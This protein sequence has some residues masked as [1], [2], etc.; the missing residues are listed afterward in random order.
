[1]GSQ[2]KVSGYKY[3]NLCKGCGKVFKSRNTAYHTFDGLST[4]PHCGSKDILTQGSNGKIV[5]WAYPA[6]N[7][8][9]SDFRNALKFDIEFRE[10]PI[11]GVL[12]YQGK[13]LFFK[14]S[15][16]EKEYEVWE[17]KLEDMEYLLARDAC[18]VENVGE[19]L[20]YKNGRKNSICCL[21]PSDLWNNYYSKYKGPW[22]LPKLL[23]KLYVVP[24]K[25]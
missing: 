22:K 1:M 14:M 15:D 24:L 23:R 8:K 18:F 19:H 13:H 3:T 16:D 5:D 9:L 11:S 7:M 4:C 21:K 25:T 10:R 20:S 2:K 17:T 6:T 12:E